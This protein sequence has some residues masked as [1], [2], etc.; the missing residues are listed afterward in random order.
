MTSARRRSLIV[1]VLTA[2]VWLPACHTAPSRSAPSASRPTST[3]GAAARTATRPARVLL[4][5]D[6]ILDQE[7]SAATFLLRQSGVDARAIGVWGSGVIGIDQYDFGRTKLS[8]YW[9]R[10]ARSEIAR[11]DPDVVGV[12]MNHSYWP[13][14]PRDAAGNPITDLWS[15][16]GQTM[17]GRQAGALIAIL[18]ARHAKVFFISPVPGATSGSADPAATNP[19]WHGYLPV[20]HALHVV[21]ADTSRPI[22]TANGL[23]AETEASCTG[24][25]QRV[26]PPGDVHLT[27]FGAGL[28][29]TALAGLVANLVHATLRGNAAPGDALAALVPTRDERGYWLVGCDG[30]V[31]HFGDA[32]PMGGERPVM[33]HH[34]GVA[35]AVASASGAGLWLVAADGTIANAGDAPPLELTT[36]PREPIVGA[37]STSDG[38][39][40]LAVSASGTVLAAGT[41][42]AARSETGAHPGAQIAGIA[43][44]PDAHG[45]W[46]LDR[47]GGV[48]ASGDAHVFGA[49]TAWHPDVRIVGI[50]DTST[51]RG[52]WLVASDGT[53]FPFGDARFRG[54]AV[55][56]RP[57]GRSGADVAPP[58]P[59]RGIVAT[60]ATE[61]GYWVFGTTGRV[62]G[63]GAAREYGGDNNL[64]LDTQ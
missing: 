26:R 39:G 13:P 4:I 57:P 3:T 14:Y 28:A 25:Q 38:R 60:R 15:Q 45:Y 21:I 6:S 31:Y 18:R 22:E 37:T 12:Y 40:L 5:G 46:L 53:V 41:V 35:A 54:T 47:R 59:A 2:T 58:G 51:G 64:A 61:Q 1:L 55:W 10:R 16:S 11:F 48:V 32:G 52:Y 42:R 50:A 36:L 44:T 20:L 8:G 34:G 49:V 43:G 29:G 33:S 23:R 7:G 19:I 63:L 56:R 17:I 9:L 62:V 27:R 30:S 24:A